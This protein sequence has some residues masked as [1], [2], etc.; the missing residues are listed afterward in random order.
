MNSQLGGQNSNLS[1]QEQ[2]TIRMMQAAMESCVVKTAM[3]GAA[4][5]AMG[6]AFGLFMSSFEY[7]GPVMNEDLVKQ[8]TKQ[9]IKHAFKD[10]GTRSLSMA[11]NFG[12][13]GM[14]YSGTECCIES[15]RA[16]NDLYN[17]VAAG[18]FT[19][20]L[21]AAKAGPQAMA[22]GAGGFAAFS[23]AIDWYM[24]RD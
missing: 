1:L 14:I 13:V 4:G 11:K 18:A 2:Q 19:G 21:L 10:M 9:Q 22:L 3:S 5:F 16:K 17:S 15:Y 12:L 6:G 23:L 24:H 8:T 20:G 7:A